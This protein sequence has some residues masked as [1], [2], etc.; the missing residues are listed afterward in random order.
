VSMSQQIMNDIIEAIKQER[1]RIEEPK[2]RS[3]YFLF[4]KIDESLGRDGYSVSFECGRHFIAFGRKVRLLYEI[5]E[6]T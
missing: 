3:R 6:Q 2:N 4:G 1:Q 5:C